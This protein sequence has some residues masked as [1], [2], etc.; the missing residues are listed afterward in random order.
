MITD[1]LR[2]PLYE[3][4]IP[5]KLMTISTP[6]VSAFLDTKASSPWHWGKSAGLAEG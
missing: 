2:L 6:V 4:V 3:S 1:D 5:S